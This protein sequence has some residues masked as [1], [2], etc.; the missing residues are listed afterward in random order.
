MGVC[1]RLFAPA[2]RFISKLAPNNN[3][4]QILA[5]QFAYCA[6]R[7][8]LNIH[9]SSRAKERS[10]GARVHLARLAMQA[11]LCFASGAAIHRL[12]IYSAEQFS[13]SGLKNYI[14]IFC[15]YL[16]KCKH[17]V[18]RSQLKCLTLITLL[19]ILNPEKLAINSY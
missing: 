19:Y 16:E 3:H 4:D 11:F 14:I 13:D 18:A 17:R 15:K 5:G 7:S 9:T 12:I 2:S 6:C 8:N 10:G 1:A